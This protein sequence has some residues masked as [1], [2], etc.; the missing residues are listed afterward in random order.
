MDNTRS[1]TTWETVL[2]MGCFKIKGRRGGIKRREKKESN[3]LGWPKT[4]ILA[5]LSPCTHNLDD[6]DSER[7]QWGMVTGL[8][9]D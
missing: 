3:G 8:Q 4:D 9:V 7:P 1:M 2:K 5:S 6:I